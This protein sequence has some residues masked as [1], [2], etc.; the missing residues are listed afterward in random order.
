[1]LPRSSIIGRVV[2]GLFAKASRP[3]LCSLCLINARWCHRDRPSNDYFE[4]G[5]HTL[6]ASNQASNSPDAS[7]KLDRYHPAPT[8]R[9][10]SGL[11]RSIVLV[12]VL[13]HTAHLHLR[14][15]FH[16]RS[17]SSTRRS[18]GHCFIFG[19]SPSTPASRYDTPL[20]PYRFDELGDRNP[21]WRPPEAQIITSTNSCLSTHL[22]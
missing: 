6:P 1:M 19:N 20:D 15:P 14:P 18:N 8:E 17:P 21:R 2:A 9:R 22:P 7:L 5:P 11:A 3:H 12:L 16:L 4:S 13:S 10:R